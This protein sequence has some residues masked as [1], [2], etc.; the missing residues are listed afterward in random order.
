MRRQLMALL[1]AGSFLLAN[2]GLQAQIQMP[3]ASSSGGFNA[4]LAKFFGANK[5]FSAQA[6]ALVRAKPTS[7]TSTIPMGFAL[8]DGKIRMELDLTRIRSK[9][10]TPEAVSM[11]KQMGMNRMV[12]V[13]APEKKLM[14]VLYPLLQAYVEL[15]LTEDQSGELK[16]ETS[17]AGKEA[18][19]GHPCAKR[20][21]VVTDEKG[22]KQEGFTWNATDLRDFPVKMEFADTEATIT[23]IFRDIKLSPPDAKAFEAPAGFTKHAD[24][25]ALMTSVSQRNARTPASK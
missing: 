10:M 12:S 2:P 22:R 4:S 6:E 3:L 24:M 8:L 7:E 20:K 18:V 1:A 13:I 23:M 21:V 19:E 17:E 15:P 5:A 16:I 11:V 14:Y 9:Q 25:Q